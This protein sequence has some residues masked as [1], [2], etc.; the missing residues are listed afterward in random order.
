MSNLKYMK[1]KQIIIYAVF[2]S[3]IIALSVLFYIHT[4]EKIAFIKTDEIFND[5]QLKKELEKE[6]TVFR[7]KKGN[8]LDSLSAMLKV[9]GEF[10]S[11]EKNESNKKK[12]IEEYYGLE[13]I[14]KNKKEQLDSQEE[15]LV[16]NFNQQIYKQINEYTQEYGEK[17]NYKFI[18]GT[19]TEGNIMYAGKSEDITH[20]VNDYIN[21]KYQGTEK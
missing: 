13:K 18:F 19:T 16:N 17:N 12:K 2:S 10:I 6:L 14:Y 20:Q 7:D 3:A 21:S 11:Q 15:Q 8:L 4:R 5:F 1:I 9:K